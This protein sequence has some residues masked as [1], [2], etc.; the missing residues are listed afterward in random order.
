MEEQTKKVQGLHDL[1]YSVELRDLFALAITA[2]YT[3][4][5]PFTAWDKSDAENI[6]NLVDKLL[7]AREATR[8]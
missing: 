6:Y 5:Y 8:K 7:E 4:Y 3:S 2:G 1:I